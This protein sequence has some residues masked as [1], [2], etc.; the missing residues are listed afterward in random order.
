MSGLTHFFRFNPNPNLEGWYQTPAQLNKFGFFVSSSAFLG[1]DPNLVVNGNVGIRCDVGSKADLPALTVNGAI[2]IGYNPTTQN[3]APLDP[4]VERAFESVGD[5]KAYANGLRARG[6]IHSDKQLD[7]PR[8]D[9]TDAIMGTASF[10]TVATPFATLKSD[11]IV[12]GAE[13]QTTS[14]KIQSGNPSW[15]KTTNTLEL[16]GNQ[17]VIAAKD[18]PAKI[19]VGKFD[20][21]K[22]IEIQTSNGTIELQTFHDATMPGES[23]AIHLRAE[24]GNVRIQANDVELARNSR[25]VTY[26]HRLNIDGPTYIEST[27]KND[28]PT[29]LQVTDGPIV[30]VQSVGDNKDPTKLDGKHIVLGNGISGDIDHLQMTPHYGIRMVWEDTLAGFHLQDITKPEQGTHRDAVMFWGDDAENR[31]RIRF[32]GNVPSYVDHQAPVTRKQKVKIPGKR[33][34]KAK[35]KTMSVTTEAK[36]LNADDLN[37]MGFSGLQGMPQKKIAFDDEGP[38]KFRDIVVIEPDGSFKVNGSV[39]AYQHRKWSDVRLK[40]SIKPIR[41]ALDKVNAMRGV[42]YRWRLGEIEDMPLNDRRQLGLLAQEIEKVCP[43]VVTTE[44]VNDR[45]TKTV[46][47]TQIV[48]VLIEAIKEQQ[49]TISSLQT[50]LETLEKRVCSVVIPSSNPRLKKRSSKRYDA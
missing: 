30:Q 36:D 10:G 39:Y 24:K 14:V 4:G 19:K 46:D 48:P 25:R 7:A 37:L 38:R 42:S 17:V 29:R 20:N 21:K 6:A 5:G 31:F 13:G 43:E 45:P 8:G 12:L 33:G 23:T 50:R 32:V 15:W 34:Q 2:A 49:E 9:F 18:N 22:G 3:N 26:Q 47:Y 35:T 16:E 40:E 11:A 41:K 27:K 1:K 44:K 28:N